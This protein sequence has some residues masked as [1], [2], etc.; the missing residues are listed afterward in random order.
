MFPAVGGL[1]YAT[2]KIAHGEYDGVNSF[3]EGFRKYF[4]TSWKYG[5]LSLAIYFFIFISIRFYSG[6]KGYGYLIFLSISIAFL[7]FWT[8]MQFYIYPFL[9]EQKE[10]SIKTAIRNSFAVFISFIGR[11]FGY[12]FF[13]MGV[14]VVSTLLPPLWIFVTVSFM[15]FTANWFTIFAIR[16]MEIESA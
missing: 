15:T 7:I 13:Y 10:A 12:L 3:F 8:C 2:N 1:F 11:S 16:D 5:L 9:L 6:F 4:W 14:I